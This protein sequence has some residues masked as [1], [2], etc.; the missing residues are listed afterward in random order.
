MQPFNEN[1]K[2]KITRDMY[3]TQKTT[4]TNKWDGLQPGLFMVRYVVM[5]LLQST[6]A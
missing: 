3:G 4:L 5:I 2:V 6:F 1:E